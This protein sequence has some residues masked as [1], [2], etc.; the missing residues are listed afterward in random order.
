MGEL[1]YYLLGMTEA[2]QKFQSGYPVPRKTSTGHLSQDIWCPH[3][4][5][6]QISHK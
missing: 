5:S 6:N 2:T 4:D 1:C 3:K